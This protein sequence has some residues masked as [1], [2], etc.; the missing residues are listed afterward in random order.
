MSSSCPLSSWLCEQLSRTDYTGRRPGWCQ[1][2][3]NRETFVL[4][5]QAMKSSQHLQDKRQRRSAER[6]EGHNE[7]LKTRKRNNSP[8][9]CLQCWSICNI[10]CILIS[11]L[12]SFGW[13]KLEFMCQ[14]FCVLAAV[15]DWAKK[16]GTLTLW[17]WKLI[18]KVDKIHVHKLSLNLTQINTL[19]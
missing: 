4:K 2:L 6:R 9:R 7:S 11:V 12:T 1:V 10:E 16:H 3:I 17:Y 19:P 5:W 8:Q 13:S 18:H 15:V 14:I